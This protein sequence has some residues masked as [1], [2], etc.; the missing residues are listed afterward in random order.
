MGF[1]VPIDEWLR[2]SLRPML[3]DVLFSRAAAT[4]GY[5]HPPVVRRLVDEHVSKRR[6]RHEQ[7]WTLLMLELW[8]LMFIDTR[9]AV[10]PASLAPAVAATG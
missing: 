8:H 4:R 3:E 1:G 7:L 10:R 9:P 2:G 5:F 6:N